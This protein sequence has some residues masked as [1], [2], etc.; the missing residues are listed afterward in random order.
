MKVSPEM[1]HNLRI[2]SLGVR[3]LGQPIEEIAPNVKDPSR[4]VEKSTGQIWA[5]KINDLDRYRLVLLLDKVVSHKIGVGWHC[6]PVLSKEELK[7]IG[8]ENHGDVH[9]LT[10]AVG[11]RGTKGNAAAVYLKAGTVLLQNDRPTVYVGTI[12]EKLRDSIYERE[13]AY[14]VSV[15]RPEND[16]GSIAEAIYK[17]INKWNFIQEFKGRKRGRPNSATL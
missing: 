1:R 7:E 6:L 15:Y 3:L 11:L 16:E 13:I 5:V 14:Y 8:V 9:S 2:V 10:G 4:K 17:S 12:P